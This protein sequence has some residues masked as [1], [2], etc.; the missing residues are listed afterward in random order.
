MLYQIWLNLIRHDRWQLILQGLGVALQI[1]FFSIIIGLI[2]GFFTALMRTSKFKALRTVAMTYVTVIRGIPMLVQLMILYFAILGPYTNLPKI[3]IAIIAFGINSG[4][5]T[6]EIFR[7]GI[8]SVDYGQT[9]AGRSLGFSTAQTMRLIILPQAVKNALPSLGNEFILLL[10][11]TS[12]AG[13]IGVQDLTKAGDIIRSRTF[14]A[15]TPLITVAII[16]LI[17]VMTLTWLLSKL[18]RR[19]RKGDTR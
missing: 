18:E 17:L 12:I 8:L 5:Y 3:L 14:S 11:E 16:Y 2:L 19:L 7:A 13:F 4:A 10:K 1:A 9:E 6:S 15:F